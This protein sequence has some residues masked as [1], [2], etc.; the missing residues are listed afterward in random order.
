MKQDGRLIG[1]ALDGDGVPVPPASRRSIRLSTYGA[2]AIGDAATLVMSFLLANLT[3]FGMFN[4][5]AGI[6]TLAVTLPIYFGV[7]LQRKPYS[8]RFLESWRRSARDAVT[9]LVT[10]IIVASVVAIYLHADLTISRSVASIAGV[11]AAILLVGSRRLLSRIAMAALK[12]QPVSTVLIVDGIAFPAL[13]NVPRVDAHRMGLSPER[14]DPVAFA[15]LNAAIGSCERVVVACAPERRA[16]W[17]AML[18][19]ANA[20]GEIV[21]PELDRMGTIRSSTLDGM[22]TAVTSLGPLDTTNRAVKRAFDLV[23]ATVAIA[24]LWPILGL[25]ALAIRLDSPGPI[26]FR[27]PRLGRGNA[28]FDVLKFRSMRT[29]LCDVAGDRSTQRADPRVTRVGRIIRATSID[30]L[31]QL[32]NVLRGSMSVVG[33]RPHALG[34]L[35][36]DKLFWEIDAQYWDRHAMKPGITGLAQVHGYRGATALPED[37]TNRLRADIAYMRGWTIWR[38]LRIMVATTRVL[39]HRNAF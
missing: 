3:R 23:V 6:A 9:A 24:L 16:D 35:A 27:Q 32:L 28:L 5:P 4:E 10:A 12:G 13:P 30:E 31:P 37:L 38:D 15:L 22:S 11:Y 8:G 21:T 25:V 34:S 19:G 18:K 1:A 29:D 2:L 14:D 7:I 36:G 33:P 17:A 39:L 20:M 26:L